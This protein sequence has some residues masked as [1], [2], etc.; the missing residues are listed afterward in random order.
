MEAEHFLD[1]MLENITE[2]EKKSVKELFEKILSTY[3]FKPK[4]EPY[5]HEDFTINPEA[6]DDEANIIKTYLYHSTININNNINYDI[7]YGNENY[8][9][10]NSDKGNKI[11]KVFKMNKTPP[12]ETSTDK[13]LP[14]TSQ[15]SV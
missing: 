14:K 4:I 11:L 1:K 8:Y 13:T 9:S 10:I 7:K 3:S 15:I 12:E 6:D 5:I 2:S